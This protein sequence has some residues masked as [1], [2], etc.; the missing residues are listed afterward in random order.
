MNN[1]RRKF[2]LLCG[3]TA[4]LCTLGVMQIHL[5]TLE[6][7][8]ID[9][10]V[11][12]SA[13][14]SYL[15]T[16]DHRLN[17]EHPPFA[18]QLAA[19]PLLFIRPDMPTDHVSWQQADQYEFAQQFLYESGN[20]PD[21][22]MF[23]GRFPII[24][25]T[26]LLGILIARW[27]YEY[28]GWLGAYAATLLYATSPIILAHGHLVTTDIPVAL[29]ITATIYFLQKSIQNKNTKWLVFTALSF[30]FAVNVKFTGLIL[31]GII[32][33][34]YVF[35]LKK[36]SKY[37]HIGV[38][39][40]FTFVLITLAITILF[41]LLT[42]SFI[43]QKF[44]DDTV[45]S[46]ERV[47]RL[48]QIFNESQGIRKLYVGAYIF[49]LESVTFPA[50]P[51]FNGLLLFL[52]HSY[53]GHESF[54]LGEYS[55]TGNPWYFPL[56][57]F[58][59]T[60][61]AI[62]ILLFLLILYGLRKSI[63]TIRLHAIQ[64]TFLKSIR[65]WLSSYTLNGIVFA[66]VPILYL[67]LAM[68]SHVNLGVRHLIP[69]FPF[70]FIG[71]TRLAHEDV[72]RKKILKYIF[73][74]IFIIGITAPFMV[75]PYP[76]AYYSEIIGGSSN[77]HKY[78]MDSNIDWGQNLKHFKSYLEANNNPRVCLH[79]FGKGNP[80]YEGIDSQPLPSREDVELGMNIDCLAAISVQL[81]YDRGNTY[82][83]LREYTPT[84]IIG[85]GLY[86]Y[87]FRRSY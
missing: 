32:P 45:Q 65:R 38:R 4:I 54:F 76:L 69:V 33:I 21:Q 46:I 56:A 39:H 68:N 72:I 42:T 79:Y 19:I 77:G 70:I 48:S 80:E 66:G 59:K 24:L 3:I 8:T 53:F 12:L 29:G 81:L 43:T 1:K 47:E 22:L 84:D 63:V 16:G 73:G 28:A 82:E 30:A 44:G 49:G 74:I 67:L 75:Y 7:Q 9:E 71:I 36:R 25:L 2:I 18:K 31:A 83:W 58:I 23:W 34:I 17:P 55:D 37:P 41:T 57:F 5:S 26:L 6:N 85:Y 10:G 40:F 61:L 11:H 60:P 50:Y 78:I 13:G 86:L 20:N 27:A 62:V 51:Y 64:N 35:L 87:D 14:Y 52:E 15:V